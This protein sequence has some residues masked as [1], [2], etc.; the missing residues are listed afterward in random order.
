MSENEKN[1]T[2]PPT[3][4]HHGFLEQFEALAHDSVEKLRDVALLGLQGFERIMLFKVALKLLEVAFHNAK[5]EDFTEEMV[6]EVNKL[7][8]ELNSH[9]PET[10]QS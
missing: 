9:V 7:V 4:D 8:E 1:D 10:I 6:E 5:E 2:E 3:A